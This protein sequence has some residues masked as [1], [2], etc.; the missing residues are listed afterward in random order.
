MDANAPANVAPQE[1]VVDSGVSDNE[2]KAIPNPS[3]LEEE[4]E[5][6]SV[7]DQAQENRAA[8]DA[9]R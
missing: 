1:E 8:V 2:N 6:N 7:G 9:G 5:I 3:L 4:G